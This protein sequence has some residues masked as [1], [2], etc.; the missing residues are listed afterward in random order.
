MIACL[1]N[2]DREA[3]HTLELAESARHIKN[4]PLPQPLLHTEQHASNAANVAAV[5]AAELS[6]ENVRA[7]F[8][9][10]R[11]AELEGHVQSLESERIVL[12]QRADE[13]EKERESLLSRVAALEESTWESPKS[14]EVDSAKIK[15]LILQFPEISCSVFASI[16]LC[17]DWHRNWRKKTCGCV[18]ELER[19]RPMCEHCRDHSQ[20]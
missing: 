17:D 8:L 12:Q 20:R 18:L 15:V 4:S 1:S 2:Q 11:I 9:E 6:V 5:A 3:V 14:V 16:S 10:G 13:L 7:A 19:W